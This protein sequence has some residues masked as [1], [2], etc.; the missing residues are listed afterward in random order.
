[1][2]QVSDSLLTYY[3]NGIAVDASGG[4]NYVDAD[5]EVITGPGATVSGTKSVTGTGTVASGLTTITSVV[6]TLKSD[7]AL[8]GNSVTATWSGGTVTLKVW[9]PTSSSDCTPIASTAAKDVSYIIT[10]S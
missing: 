9:K 1:M 4:I 10:G 7:A 3:P 8:T 5:G 6:A 2:A